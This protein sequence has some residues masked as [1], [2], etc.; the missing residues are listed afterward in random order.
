VSKV[1]RNVLFD[2]ETSMDNVAKYTA[3]EDATVIGDNIDNPAVLAL[4][5]HIF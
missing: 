2:P 1:C 4:R 5:R 3:L